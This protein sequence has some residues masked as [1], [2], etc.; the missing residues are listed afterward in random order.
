MT[1]K[2]SGETYVQIKAEAATPKGD[3]SWGGTGVLVRRR[4]KKT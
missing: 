3:I 2:S 1:R 4:Q